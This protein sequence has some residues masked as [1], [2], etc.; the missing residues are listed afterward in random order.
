MQTVSFDNVA[1]QKKSEGKTLQAR[2]ERLIYSTHFRYINSFCSG[3]IC[4][5]RGSSS[6]RSTT[7]HL[8]G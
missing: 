5:Y 7:I 4:T 1:L 3:H 6:K 8:L 2:F